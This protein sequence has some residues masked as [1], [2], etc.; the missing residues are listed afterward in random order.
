[1]QNDLEGGL[2]RSDFNY[3]HADSGRTSFSI[4]EMAKS[5][6]C[7]SWNAKF[8]QLY[9]NKQDTWP[10]TPIDGVIRIGAARKSL[11][12]SALRQ[13]CVFDILSEKIRSSVSSYQIN[14]ALSGGLDSQVIALLAQDLGY[15]VKGYFLSSGI[16]GYCEKSEILSFAEKYKI[17]TEEI[18]VTQSDFV[19]EHSTLVQLTEY[20]IYNLHAVSKLLLAQQLKARG[21]FQ[22]FSGDGADQMISGAHFCDL[23][24]LTKLCF[25]K[26]NIALQAPYV[27]AEMRHWVKANGPLINKEPLRE[28]A[29]KKWG[30]APIAKKPTLFPEVYGTQ[31]CLETSQNYLGNILC[32]ESQG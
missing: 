31:T 16:H 15:D 13:D 18:S 17:K 12:I 4:F 26:M 21:V 9:K 29:Q 7:I 27:C 28:L 23:Y 30:L 24:F 22:I 25:E 8:W 32:V 14:V 2:L 6:K 1:M 10:L 3:F 19:N 20:P 5:L 11:A